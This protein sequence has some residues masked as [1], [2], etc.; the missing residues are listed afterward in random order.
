LFWRTAHSR[1]KVLFRFLPVQSLSRSPPGFYGEAKLP[2]CKASCCRCKQPVNSGQL[3]ET[4]Q[5]QRH[6]RTHR[7]CGQLPRGRRL[8]SALSC[9]SGSAPWGPGSGRIM[10]APGKVA[11]TMCSSRNLPRVLISASAW[12]LSLSLFC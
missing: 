4:S 3:L 6:S 12:A 9:P 7:G 1:P 11:G 2:P 10:W 5:R 8:L